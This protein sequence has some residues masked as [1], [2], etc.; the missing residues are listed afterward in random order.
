MC[1][2]P[3]KAAADTENHREAVSHSG[4]WGG[5]AYMRRFQ[6]QKSFRSSVWTLERGW[7][8]YRL[9]FVSCRWA[10]SLTVA[11]Q[12]QQRPDY[13]Q[14]CRAV[15]WEEVRGNRSTAQRT[16]S[17]RAEVCR[18]IFNDT[19][20][21]TICGL[22]ANV[23]HPQEP[24]APALGAAEPCKYWLSDARWPLVGRFRSQLCRVRWISCCLGAPQCSTRAI[25]TH[26]TEPPDAI[27]TALQRHPRHSCRSTLDVERLPNLQ[28]RCR[29]TLSIRG[30]ASRTP[31]TRCR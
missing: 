4:P 8:R 23:I 19:I 2:L 21:R 15:C 14:G 6:R 5:W 10:A 29:S 26:T 16:T 25:P 7:Y 31:T 13:H 24:T 28:R 17:N 3:C 11:R 9:G 27:S 22:Y 12:Q 18:K 20:V 30:T 1:P